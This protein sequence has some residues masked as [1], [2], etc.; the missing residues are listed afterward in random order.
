MKIEKINGN[1]RT[2]LI[3][4][5]AE[6]SRKN[7]KRVPPLNDLSERLG[8]SIASLREQLEVAR[9]MGLVDIK[10]KRGITLRDYSLRP[11]LQQSIGYA[12]AVTPASFFLF[13]DLRNHLEAAYWHQAV[14]LLT[15][16]DYDLLQNLIMQAAEKLEIQ[17]IQIPKS[18]HRELHL[19]IFSRLNNL[20]VLGILETFWDLYGAVG[21]DLYTDY[22]YLKIVWDYH[23]QIVDS[24]LTGKYD[25]GYQLLLEHNNLLQK[26]AKP[27]FNQLFE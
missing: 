13:L 24:I 8:V 14:S 3:S 12:V 15:S 26:R 1:S 4:L 19:T 9:V 22:D 7:Q 11:A 2:E 18:E 23:K 21:F 27:N 10:P 16:E 20:F 17:P 6:M 5:L 25:W